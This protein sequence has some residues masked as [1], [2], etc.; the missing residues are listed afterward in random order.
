M[1]RPCE[2]II[3]RLGGLQIFRMAEILR[4][5]REVRLAMAM[6]ISPGTT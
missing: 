1:H 5:Y 2:P 4:D 6:M 3:E